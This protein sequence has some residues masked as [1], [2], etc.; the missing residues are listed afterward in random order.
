LQYFAVV[1]NIQ[2]TEQCTQTSLTSSI[3]TDTQTFN[4]FVM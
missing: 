4:T 2:I 1:T 3:V